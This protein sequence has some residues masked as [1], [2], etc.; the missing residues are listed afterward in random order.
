MLAVIW[1][2]TKQWRNKKGKAAK[3]GRNTAK[4]SST[5]IDRE[6]PLVRE[7][8]G[9]K[10]PHGQK[11][12]RVAKRSSNVRHTRRPKTRKLSVLDRKYRQSG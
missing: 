9:G 10:A 3:E 12:K 4:E 6:N 5:V 2:R 8:N 11:R 1:G 7:T